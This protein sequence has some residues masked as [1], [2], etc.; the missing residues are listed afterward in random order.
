MTVKTWGPE[1]TELGLCWYWTCDV[2]GRRGGCWSEA[3][4]RRV[5]AY[6]RKECKR[7]GQ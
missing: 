4:R 3:D 2:C 6:H 7:L 1:K 5:T